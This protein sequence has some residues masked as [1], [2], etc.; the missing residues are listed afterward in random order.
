MLFCFGD[1]GSVSSVTSSSKPSN[2][3]NSSGEKASVLVHPVDNVPFIQASGIS[4]AFRSF[5]QMIF[6]GRVEDLFGAQSVEENE[7]N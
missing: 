2:S 6:P 4:G 7:N 1:S 3:F 5:Y